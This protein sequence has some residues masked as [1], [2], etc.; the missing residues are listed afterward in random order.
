MKTEKGYDVKRD[1]QDII[2]YN[3]NIAGWAI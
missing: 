2:L 3:P 1:G